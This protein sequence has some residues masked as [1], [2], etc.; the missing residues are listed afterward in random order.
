MAKG[1]EKKRF[2]VPETSSTLLKVVQ[3]CDFNQRSRA[4]SLTLE[5][6]ILRLEQIEIELL[7][8]HLAIQ[9]TPS[10]SGSN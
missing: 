7:I 2:F 5:Y 4:R 8:F 9:K 6:F 1:G 10:D 3:S